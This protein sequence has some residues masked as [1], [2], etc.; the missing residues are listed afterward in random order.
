MNETEH[1]KKL[2]EVALPLEPINSEARKRK[3]GRAPK[4]Y[5]TTIHKYW[6]QRPISICR[7]VIFCQ[8]VDD[9]SAWPDKFTTKE[10]QDIERMRLF[11]FIEQ[12]VKWENS[13]NEYILNKA[14]FEIARSIAWNRGEEPP[15]SK[16]PK[17]VLDYL[18]KYAPPVYDPFSG[19]G[20]I[21]LEAQRLGLRG[22]GSDLNPVA[23]L[24]GKALVEVPPKFAGQPPVNPKRDPHVRWK[25]A[26]G[27]ASDVRYYGKRMRDKALKRIGKLYPKVEITE[28]DVSEQPS[29]EPLKGQK[30]T[31]VA[32]IWARTVITPNPAAN[33]AQVPLVS[34]FMLSTKG[35]EKAWVE[36]KINPNAPDGYQFVVRSGRIS[37]EDQSKKDAGTI[38]K[39]TGGGIVF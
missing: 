19:S 3:A 11:D 24:I 9:P 4:G 22:Y 32:W 31:V 8:L 2:I 25:G 27:L 29:L 12:L 37:K 18:Q 5:P 34:S 10:A 20:S 36:P 13:T 16:K 39:S 7:A 33:G 23:V 26:Q 30:L 28:K 35:S 15:A 38:G 17:Q 6:A 21:P 1:R 14:R